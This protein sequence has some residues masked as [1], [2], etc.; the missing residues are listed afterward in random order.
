[1]KTIY[2]INKLALQLVVLMR[3]PTGL[4]FLLLSATVFD[5]LSNT[6]AIS[7]LFQDRML[8]LVQAWDNSL[9]HQQASSWSKIISVGFSILI[10]TVLALGILI[11]AM[12]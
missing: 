2:K 3:S 1:M 10:S 6:L 8:S 4:I 12:Q 9:T 7:E 11:T 5:G